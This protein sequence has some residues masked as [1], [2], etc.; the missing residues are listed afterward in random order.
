MNISFL[1]EWLEDFE[2]L[3]APLED[4]DGDECFEESHEIDGIFVESHKGYSLVSVLEL[5]SFNIRELK[6]KVNCLS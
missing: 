5:N 1:G 3:A 2:S 4:E 6:C